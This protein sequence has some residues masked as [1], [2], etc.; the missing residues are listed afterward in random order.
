MKLNRTTAALPSCD[1]CGKSFKSKYVLK[2]HLLSESSIKPFKCDICEKSFTRRDGLSM[3]K[4]SHIISHPFQC[5]HC[6][7]AYTT[8]FNISSHIKLQHVAIISGQRQTRK[9]EC[10]LCPFKG[11][12]E[13]CVRRHMLVHLK[14]HKCEI[15]RKSFRSSTNLKAHLKQHGN[16]G[17]FVCFCGREFSK[18]RY[19]QRHQFSAHAEAV[20]DDRPY[21][22]DLC[23]HA[24]RLKSNL[25]CH[26][27]VHVDITCSKCNEVLNSKT[28][29]Q[30][31]LK[32]H[33][34]P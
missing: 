2:R 20:K 31:H 3:H 17:N 1:N 29:F 32:T 4:A 11:R 21:K 5:D 23:P 9:S 13:R 6:P 33:D 34:K 7:K 18:T 15:C 19:M 25:Q 27:R 24:A 22:C 8:R 26:K 12:T 14:P 16:T 30:K 10:K 28:A